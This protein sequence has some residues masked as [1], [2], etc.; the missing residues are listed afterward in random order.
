MKFA[1]PTVTLDPT[2]VLS[3]N[4]DIRALKENFTINLFTVNKIHD[5]DRS[6]LLNRERTFGLGS[7]C[8]IYPTLIVNVV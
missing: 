1:P 7:F 5:R 2:S 4:T 3:G 8:D 6:F